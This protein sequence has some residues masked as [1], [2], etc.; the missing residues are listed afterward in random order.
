M[1]F[2]DYW[3]AILYKTDQNAIFFKPKT[4]AERVIGFYVFLYLFGFVKILALSNIWAIIIFIFAYIGFQVYYEEKYVSHLVEVSKQL[5]Q[6][7]TNECKKYILFFK[8][9]AV[10]FFV[11]SFLRNIL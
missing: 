2:M 7:Q 10:A 1:F 11:L 8:I 6:K 5:S 9:L 3:Y 4:K